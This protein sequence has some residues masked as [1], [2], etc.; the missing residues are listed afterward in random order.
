MVVKFRHVFYFKSYFRDFLDAQR[1]KVAKKI[2]WTLD[3]IETTEVVPKQYLKSV[4]G[5]DGL[6]EVRVMWASDIFRIFCFFD[7][8]RLVVLT[9]GFQKKS[10]KTPRREIERAER[11]REEYYSEKE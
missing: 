2:F 4:E 1:P 6:F 9:N 3:F 11:I 8:G 10:Q 7:E 5:A